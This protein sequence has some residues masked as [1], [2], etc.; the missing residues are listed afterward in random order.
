MVRAAALGSILLLW[1]EQRAGARGV[2]PADE[3]PLMPELTRR[4]KHQAEAAARAA[5]AA[6]RPF[7]FDPAHAARVRAAAAAHR[8]PGDEVTLFL[9]VKTG[10]GL[11]NARYR[12]TA[13]RTWLDV[14]M[15]ELPE[16]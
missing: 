9:A 16:V 10:P 7:T 13:R 5:K 12:A 11:K 4:E 8:R 14:G 3:H 2:G 1:S 15:K 6:A